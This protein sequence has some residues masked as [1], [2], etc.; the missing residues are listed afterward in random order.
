MGKLD[1]A[2]Q[3]KWW[4]TRIEKEEISY[5]LR[6]NG[7][8]TAKSP[9]KEV[10]FLNTLGTATVAPRATESQLYGPGAQVL[11]KFTVTREEAPQRSPAPS[12]AGVDGGD[13]RSVA[14]LP[15]SR[16]GSVA[17]SA[18][19][20]GAP[21]P[22]PGS[23]AGSRATSSKSALQARLDKLEEALTFERTKRAEAEEEMRQLQVLQMQA[24]RAGRT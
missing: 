22:A 3:D 21:P 2:Q 24:R 9:R 14:S 4:K 20:A 23:A 13:S 15:A 7:E 1:P 5:G 11:P 19:A 17:G 6:G 18:A 12:V 16:P 10:T 8:E